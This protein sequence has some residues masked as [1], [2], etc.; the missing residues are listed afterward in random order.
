MSTVFKWD[1]KDMEHLLASCE[2]DGILP[3]VEKYM[4]APSYILESGCGL[5]RY[6]KYLH[7]RGWKVVG[8]EINKDAVEATKKYWPEL[9]IIQGDAVESPFKDNV[10]DG[11]I[12]LGVIEHWTE[13]PN[14]A[15]ADI[16]RTLKPGGT[17]LITTPCVNTI[18][19]IKHKIWWD[20]RK[21]KEAY[22]NWRKNNKPLPNRLNKKYKFYTFLAFGDFFEYRFTK[23]E[24]RDEVL[25][26]GLKII[27]HKPS[28]VIDGL[29]H[30]LNPGKKLV[31]FEDWKFKP[32]ISGKAIN[33]ALATFPF[34]HPHMQIII[35]RK[36]AK[37]KTK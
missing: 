14:A 34:F 8:L 27:E 26:S 37:S 31:K 2:T 29:Y 11:V 16:Y 12:S 30:D 32:S 19:N 4:P 22:S 6:V 5:G 33:K 9:E 1:T 24:F 20:E 17:A 21:D 15:I 25:K 35:A 7:D 28:A 3:Y 36:P 13:G 10:F 23:K 18:R